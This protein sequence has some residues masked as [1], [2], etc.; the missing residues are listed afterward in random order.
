MGCFHQYN[1]LLT[2]E[3]RVQ[4][5]HLDREGDFVGDA[6]TVGL[7]ARPKFEVMRSVIS[8]LSVQMVDFLIRC[9]R[10][11]KSLFHNKTM[12]LNTYH[13]SARTQVDWNVKPNIAIALGLAC[14]AL[15]AWRMVATKFGT[16]YG[17]ANLFE[18]SK[19]SP[20]VPFDWHRIAANDAIRLPVFIG[21]ALSDTATF[22]RAIHRVFTPCLSVSAQ[23]ARLESELISTGTAVKR[24]ALGD[25]GRRPTLVAA[26]SSGRQFALFGYGEILAALRAILRKHVVVLI[27]DVRNYDYNNLTTMAR[28]AAQ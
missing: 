10:A 4:P 28:G 13:L 7:A 25:D 6:L 23:G 21:K 20:N 19:S 18:S 26:K 24:D 14:D 16:A 11:A 9:K 1:A 3:L 15:G 17:A 22:G 5:Q 8:A 27:V 12:L 2:R